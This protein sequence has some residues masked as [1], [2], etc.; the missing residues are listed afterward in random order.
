VAFSGGGYLGM[1]GPLI[2]NKFELRVWRWDS[3]GN[4]LWIKQYAKKADPGQLLDNGDGTF[5]ITATN[6]DHA[7]NTDPAWSWV[8]VCDGSGNILSQWDCVLV[9]TGLAARTRTGDVFLS[10]V[11]SDNF[12]RFDGV[13]GNPI[14]YKMY[15]PTANPFPGEEATVIRAMPDGGFVFAAENYTSEYS[16]VLVR[17]NADGQVLWAKNY[18]SDSFSD[19][20]PSYPQVSV[21]PDGGFLF[22]ANTSSSAVADTAIFR[23]D[24]SGNVLWQERLVSKDDPRM[25]PAMVSNAADCPDGTILVWGGL[26]YG[27][28]LAALDPTGKPL[29]CEEYGSIEGD[30]PIVNAWPVEGGYLFAS[31]GINRNMY[32]IP[33]GP[34]LSKVDLSG[35]SSSSCGSSSFNMAAQAT[36]YGVEDYPQFVTDSGSFPVNATHARPTEVTG[37]RD[38]VV[39]GDPAITAVTQLCTPLRLKL[40]GWNFQPDSVALINGVEAPEMNYK[41]MDLR[42]RTT[43]VL[44]GNG[45]RAMLPKGQPVCITIQNSTGDQS[46]C[47]TFTR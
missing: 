33:Q 1:G 37:V 27:A 38:M 16:S 6:W 35:S 9:E 32:P 24:P 42:G 22:I 10:A 8:I 25:S 36:A 46:D 18:R 34:S 12:W 40:V 23:L 4:L 43:L 5:T 11:Y 47:F 2:D 13:T 7:T 3:Q 39:C 28:F 29:W 31:Y 14:W 19:P 30:A 20:T 15:T 45:L 41:G 21:T 17:A 26:G 44:S